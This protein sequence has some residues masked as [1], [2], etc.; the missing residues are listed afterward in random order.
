M[1][2]YRKT[3]IVY[4]NHTGHVSGAERVLLYMVR[5]LDRAKY[6]PY[7]LCPA[8]SDLSRLLEAEG[9]LCLPAAPVQARFTRRP[10]LL[11]RYAASLWSAMAAMRKTILAIDPD[12]VHANTLRAG[13]V[14]TLATIGTHLTV[15]WHIHDILPRHPLSTAIRILACLSGRTRMIA[16]SEATAKSFCGALP[17]S[18]KVRTIHNG[19]DLSRFPLKQKGSSSF[20]QEAGIPDDAFVVC[21]VGQIC[22]R[23]G[24]RE[25]LDA[26]SMICTRAPEMYVAFVGKTVFQHEE[27]YRESLLAKTVS[28]AMGDRVRFTGEREDIPVVLQSA[29]LLVLNSLEEPF[30][31]V[32]VE[33]MSSGTPVLAARVGGIPE[34]VKDSENGWLVERGDTA[35]LAAKLLELSQN[36]DWLARV[37]Q[38]AQHETCPQFSLER[39]QNKLHAY[40]AELEAR[41]DAQWGGRKQLVL[42]RRGNKQGDL[43]A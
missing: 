4:I 19:I 31:L 7:V 30:G 29:D 33:A 39:F 11:M 3:R 8:E 9:V 1:I 15:I 26:F 32:L 6:E 28:D 12:V 27:Q 35:I 42:A 37:A 13:I 41:P 25:L 22:A 10:D 23:K 34:I 14:A 36:R 43:H 16:V 24:L 20:R 40:Y 2:H 38:L 17:L 18:R 5:G 21:A